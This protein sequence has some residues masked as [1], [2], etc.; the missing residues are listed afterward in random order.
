MTLHEKLRYLRSLEKLPQHMIADIL[1]VERS[2][3]SY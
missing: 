2:T 1:Q 3:Y